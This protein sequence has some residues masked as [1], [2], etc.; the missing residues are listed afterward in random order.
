MGCTS[1]PGRRLCYIAKLKLAR[2]ALQ[3]S[4][5]SFLGLVSRAQIQEAV[6]ALDESVKAER[7]AILE[8]LLALANEFTPFQRATSKVRSCAGSVCVQAGSSKAGCV[9]CKPADGYPHQMAR[10][11]SGAAVTSIFYVWLH[12]LA[13]LRQ[14]TSSKPH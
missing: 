3:T 6:R 4:L 13:S 1:E 12:D 11:Q 7:R 2:L 8:Q 10:H 5:C 14:L 9:S